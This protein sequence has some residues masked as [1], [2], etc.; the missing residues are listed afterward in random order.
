M[1]V[2]VNAEVEL[3]N[4]SDNDLINQISKRL[5]EKKDKVVELQET[6]K[7]LEKLNEKLVISE[8]NKS[9]FLSLIRNE[10]NNPLFGLIP[11]LEELLKNETND[12][13]KEMLGLVYSQTLS[14]NY[15]LNNVMVVAEIETNML[16]K[17]NSVFRVES[18]VAD[19]IHTVS[20]VYQDKKI[21]VNTN[22]EAKDEICNDREKIYTIL[23]NLLS[24]AFEFSKENSTIYLD[25]HELHKNL[26]FRIQ[27]DGYEK[28]E[29]DKIFDTFHHSTKYNR[30]S[31][32]LGIGL[33]VVKS[34]IEFLGGKID[35]EVDGES[36]VFIFNIPNTKGDCKDMFVNNID[37]CSFDFDD[38]FKNVE[39]K[40]F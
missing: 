12:I 14:M 25:I 20:F 7:E 26:I 39:I 19:I 23:D 9:K 4:I 31:K 32:G 29:K 22:I 38:D 5:Q 16:E 11:L 6:Y 10:F 28:V 33:S 30:K 27:N 13:K 3:D 8:G 1:K 15:Q 2:Y 24:N 40:K 35:V 18:I 21:K 34:Y 37:N 17:S 36:N